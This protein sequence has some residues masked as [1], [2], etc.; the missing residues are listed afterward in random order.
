MTAEQ[1]ERRAGRPRSEDADR[2][3]I[4]A[5]LDLL[6]EVGVEP[7]SI[8]QVAARA[9]VGKATIY[10]RWPNKDALIVHAMGAMKGPIPELSGKS[11][12]DDLYLLLVQSPGS[13]LHPGRDRRLYIR[14][15]AEIWRYPEMAQLFQETV[16][17]P[18][19][20][21][22]RQALRAAIERGELR[23]DIDIELMRQVITGPV[24][25]WITT[26]TDVPADETFLDSVLGVVLQGLGPRD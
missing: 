2:A 11:L 18:R 20:E 19:Q 14:M 3:I 15:R 8:E 13:R 22:T 6:A 23:D 5:T 9:G 7:L 1:V 21:A 16:I 24:L 26:H 25:Q 4:D 10:R 12:R 17:A